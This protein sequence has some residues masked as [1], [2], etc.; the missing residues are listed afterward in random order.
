MKKKDYA[1]KVAAQ[2]S[3]SF[4]AEE[5]HFSSTHVAVHSEFV[6]RLNGWNEAY[7]YIELYFDTLKEIGSYPIKDNVYIHMKVDDFHQF[8]ESGTFCLNNI[9]IDKK[10]YRGSFKCLTL[11]GIQVEGEFE[12]SQA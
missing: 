7:D 3:M 6:N 12:V 10:Q 9:D 8:A 4:H 11:D 1:A 2:G 5:K